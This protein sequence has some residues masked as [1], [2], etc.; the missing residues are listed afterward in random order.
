MAN[1]WEE[2]HALDLADAARIWREVMREWLA[3]RRGKRKVQGKKVRDHLYV[4]LQLVIGKLLPVHDIS[5]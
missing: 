5:W 4:R 2:M 1:S 3:R